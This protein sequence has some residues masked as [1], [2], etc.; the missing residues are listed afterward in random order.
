MENDYSSSSE[1]NQNSLDDNNI[2]S[3]MDLEQQLIQETAKFKELQ[4]NLDKITKKRNNYFQYFQENQKYPKSRDEYDALI[5]T[6]ERNKQTLA[7]L[8]DK[9]NSLHQNI[10]DVFNQLPEELRIQISEL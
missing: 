9:L 3:G 6:L 5:S 2:E 7:I 4:K 1:S 10:Y 8:Q